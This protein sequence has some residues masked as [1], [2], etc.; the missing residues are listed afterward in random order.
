MLLNCVHVTGKPLFH[1]TVSSMEGYKCLF[2]IYLTKLS[3]PYI[4]WRWMDR[5]DKQRIG[6]DVQGCQSNDIWNFIFISYS[7]FLHPIIVSVKCYCCVWSHSGPH[8]VCRTPLDE[9]SARRR[10]LY[11][12]THNIH[13]RQTSTPSAGFETAIPASEW[14]QTHAL[15]NWNVTKLYLLNAVTGWPLNMKPC[16]YIKQ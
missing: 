13:K 5:C 1:R 8:T 9:G 10:D 11:L 4:M 2:L 6:K 14:P 12:T 7:D 16:R 3:I 15:D